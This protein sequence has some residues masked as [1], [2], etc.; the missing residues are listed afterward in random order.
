[1]SKKFAII[2]TLMLASVSAFSQQ[3]TLSE[4]FLD[5]VIVTANKTEQKQSTT[6]KIISVITKEQIEKSAGKTITQVLNEQ[7]GLNITGANSNYGLNKGLFL[8]GASGNYTVILLDGI[9]L[10]DP[11][12][13]GGAYDL[14]SLS[15]NNIERIEIL[16]GSQST[17][18]GSNAI[19]GV[20]NIITTKAAS[21]ELE[22]NAVLS[23]GSYNTMK[24]GIDFSKNGKNFDYDI[25]YQYTSSNG[26]AEAKDTLGN[27]NFPKNGFTQNALQAK[28]GIHVTDNFKITPYYRYSN[29]NGTYSAGAF[30]GGKNGD[31]ITLQNAGFISTYNYSLRGSLTANYGYDY[32]HSVYN[33]QLYGASVSTGKFHHAEMYVQQGL[34][35]RLQLVGGLSF[36]S[37]SIPTVDTSNSLFSPYLNLLFH[38]NAWNIAVGGRFNHHN[39]FGN[40]FT[41]S[42]NPSY[43]IQ[44]KIKIFANLSTGFRAASLTEMLPSAYNLANFNLKPEESLNFEA[45]LQAWFFQKKLS[46]TASYFN[47]SIKNI[48]EYATVD[49]VTYASQYINRDKQHDQGVEVELSY[50]PTTWF[51]FK[52]SYTYIYGK[53]T[54]QLTAT[55]DTSFYNLSRRPK[56]AINLFAGFQAAK[57]LF[58]STS[59]Q[60]VGQRFDNAFDPVTFA[61]VQVNLKSYALWNLYAEYA[62]FKK[63]IVFFIDAKNLTNNTKYYEVYGYTV[64]GFNVNGGARIKL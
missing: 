8:L 19:A 12:G 28:L 9:P 41:Y 36:Q 20:I 63:R 2:S 57:N 62:A 33:D 35:S 64:Q 27:Q 58:I 29:F 25:N 43:L 32:T 38:T 52:G 59:L 14:R 1:M 53:A 10:N 18:Y 15:L 3:D 61:S 21:H 5:P 6:G 7:C 55:T 34:S 54:E 16:K 46:A 49:P 22:G 40:N 37:F 47:R 56:N 42:I 23:Y 17:L 11:S 24:G 44:N 50:K 31:N 4:K 60:S 48:I 30:E 26:I 13:L 45:G 51:T 39:R